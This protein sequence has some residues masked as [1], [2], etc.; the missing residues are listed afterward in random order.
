MR[1]V[2]L[3]QVRERCG[4]NLGGCDEFL[5]LAELDELVVLS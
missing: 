5:V 4:A 2:R 1:L 3:Q